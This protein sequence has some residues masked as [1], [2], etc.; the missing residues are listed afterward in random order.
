MEQQGFGAGV[1]L[2]HYATELLGVVDDDRR[3]LTEAAILAKLKSPNTVTV[4]DYGRDG[5]TFFIAME[6]LTGEPLDRMLDQ[7]GPLDATRTIAIAQQVCR[8][9]LGKFL[10]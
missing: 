4:F 5:D 1:L 9:T 6:L 2:V 8:G 3:N 7:H 10:C